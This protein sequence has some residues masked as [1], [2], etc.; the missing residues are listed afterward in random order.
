[1]I[2]ELGGK[3]VLDLGCGAGVFLTQLALKWPDGRGI[4]IDMNREAIA[5]AR[6]QAQA[7]GV[8][9]RVEFHVD[10]LSDQPLK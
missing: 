2:G 8:A 4:G 5:E 9:E 1:M 10:K 3:C 7:D 6:A